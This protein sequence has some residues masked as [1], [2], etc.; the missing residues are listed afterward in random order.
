MSSHVEY[1]CC[2]FFIGIPNIS[3]ML[4]R[5]PLIYIFSNYAV[6][7]PLSAVQTVALWVPM[8]CQAC[9]R[10]VKTQLEDTEGTLT[11]ESYQI[12]KLCLCMSCDTELAPISS[13]GYGVY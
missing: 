3:L 13:F 12:I 8:C 6:N 2:I 1:V 5:L 11:L 4:W 10:K 7:M 9:E